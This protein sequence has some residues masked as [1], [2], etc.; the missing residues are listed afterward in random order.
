MCHMKL[1]MTLTEMGYKPTGNSPR[2]GV[3]LTNS[4]EEGERTNQAL[5][6]AQWLSNE[7]KEANTIKRD[8]PIMCVIGNPPYSGESSNKGNYHFNIVGP[9]GT[10]MV[11]VTGQAGA[12]QSTGLIRRM[13][14]EIYDWEESG[15][16]AECLAE[17]LYRIVLGAHSE[18][19]PISKSVKVE[20]KLESLVSKFSH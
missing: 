15:D 13:A 18:S 1:D 12:P 16:L 8:M 9:N 4:L 2:F 14:A 20:S 17:R 3:Y 6:F 5:P 10:Q 11:D 19:E 7:A